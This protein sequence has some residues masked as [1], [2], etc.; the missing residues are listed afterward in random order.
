M[1]TNKI[2]KNLDDKNKKTSVNSMDTKKKLGT[3]FKT[4]RVF[5]DL[6]QSQVATALGIERSTYT[7]YETGKTEPNIKT[8]MKILKILGIT[9]EEFIR[10]VNYQENSSNLNL[11]DYQ[12]SVTEELHSAEKE[13]IYELSDEEQQLLINFRVM[14]QEEKESVLNSMEKSIK[15]NK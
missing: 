9:Y 8:T 5:N 2:N 12:E 1:A 15:D 10:C 3:L 4:Y 13:S 11:H 7:Y 6:T 14:R